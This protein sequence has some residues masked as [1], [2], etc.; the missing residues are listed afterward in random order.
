MLRRFARLRRVE[1]DLHLVESLLITETPPSDGIVVPV[2]TGLSDKEVLRS[3]IVG[4]TWMDAERVSATSISKR[5]LVGKIAKREILWNG[6][7]YSLS[8]YSKANREVLF[9]MQDRGYKIQLVTGDYIPEQATH[10]EP[11]IQNRLLQAESGSVSDNAP[12]VRF[13]LPRRE[14]ERRMRILWFMTETL[15]MHPMLVNRIEAF[16]D[17]LWMPTA[18]NVESFRESGGVI[19]CQVMPLGVDPFVYHPPLPHQK[20]DMPL[21][22]RI[23]PTPCTGHPDGMVFLYV[24]Q[25]IFRKGADFLASVFDQVFAG[26]PDAHLVLA[27]TTYPS[28]AFIEQVKKAAGKSNVWILKKAMTETQM[29]ELYRGADAYVTASMGEGWNLPLC[30][31]AMTGLPVIAPLHTA[32]LDYLTERSAFLYPCDGEEIVPSSKAVC[33]WYDGMPFAKLGDRARAGLAACLEQVYHGYNDAFLRAG[34]LRDR[35]LKKF[36]WDQAADRVDARLD[37][38]AT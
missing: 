14:E 5:G 27:T 3:A 10:P 4:D 29:A 8:G 15:R 24:F 34:R 30:E 11:H 6:Y 17:E 20:P 37:D 28:E 23:S 18:W 32:H 31:A 26:N 21:C 12:L 7:V 38:L 9:R 16:Y 13:F 1:P 2:P 22:E 19:P 33:S 36:T 25:P 35:M